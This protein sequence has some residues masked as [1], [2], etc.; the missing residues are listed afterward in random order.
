MKHNLNMRVRNVCD[1]V[2]SYYGH[3]DAAQSVFA[4]N[5]VNATIQELFRYEYPTT[6]WANGDLID[7][8]TDIDRGALTYQYGQVGSV[9]SGEPGAEGIVAHNATDIPEVDLN[10]EFPVGRIHTLA[11]SFSFSE[12]DLD[13]ARLQGMFDLAA[14][15][16][17]AAKEKHDRDL[18]A[19][20]AFGS[21]SHALEG[22]TNGTGITVL[23]ATTGNWATATALQITNDFAAAYDLMVASTGGVEEPD[24]AVLAPSIHARLM[25]LQNSVASDVSVLTYLSEQY[26]IKFEKEA[27]MSLADG[28]GGNAMLLYRRDRTKV[29]AVM[30]LYLEPTPPQFL[31]LVTKVVLR[32][33]FGGVMIPRPLSILRLDGI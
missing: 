32:S 22:I 16:A 3:Y 9:G 8:R 12:Q 4:A 23:P 26:G 19:L 21:A 24:T 27:S 31:G 2:K 7:F 6:R 14:E 17:R 29:S 10:G 20:I 18:N 25:G 1:S 15:K 5:L 11:C 13:S 30:P 28:E 33:R